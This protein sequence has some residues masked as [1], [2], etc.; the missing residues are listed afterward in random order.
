MV[1]RDGGS[2]LLSEVACVFCMISSPLLLSPEILLPSV[3]QQ[4]AMREPFCKS[5]MLYRYL[6]LLWF[7]LFQFVVG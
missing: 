3:T 5:C 6:I 4:L 7:S 2:G 1:S